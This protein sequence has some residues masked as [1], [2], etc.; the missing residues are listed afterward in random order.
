MET[1]SSSLGCDRQLVNRGSIETIGSQRR[2]QRGARCV[3]PLLTKEI[4]TI[5]RSF[6]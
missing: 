1:P 6:G 3:L 5:Y 4:V 2:I